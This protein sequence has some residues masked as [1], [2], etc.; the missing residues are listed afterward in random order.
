MLQAAAAVPVPPAESQSPPQVRPALSRQQ[1]LFGGSAAS[2]PTG[3]AAVLR[4]RRRGTTLPPSSVRR[5]RSRSPQEPAGT[6]SGQ[7]L[8]LGWSAA[9]SQQPTTPAPGAGLLQLTGRILILEA[10]VGQRNQQL[11]DTEAAGRA[12]SGRV[13]TLTGE[14]NL[15]A[16]QLGQG[17]ATMEEKL[18]AHL[19][20]IHCTLR[21]CDGIL[22]GICNSYQQ[23]PQL[24]LQPRQV[25][26]PRISQALNEPSRR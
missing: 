4:S 11:K 13:D 16:A 22:W 1:G 24:R 26:S 17:R 10:M 20:E 3:H 21:K 8:M 19:V 9:T 18:G 6:R 15:Y 7:A 23:P 25:S 2:V 12:T 14:L 5:R